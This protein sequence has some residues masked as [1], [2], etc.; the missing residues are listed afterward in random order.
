MTKKLILLLFSYIYL[1]VGVA[2]EK[3]VAEL[4]ESKIDIDV[5][6]TGATISI[7]FSQNGLILWCMFHVGTIMK[8]VK[9]DN[10]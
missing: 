4:F 1:S 5:G 8:L 6:F 2:K 7:L 9:I 3:L 10:R